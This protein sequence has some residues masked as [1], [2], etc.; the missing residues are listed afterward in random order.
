[1]IIND[2]YPTVT[3]KTSIMGMAY[4][5]ELQSIPITTPE[6]TQA[7]WLG[8][9]RWENLPLQ[10]HVSRSTFEDGILTFT[11]VTKPENVPVGFSIHNDNYIDIYKWA[12]SGVKFNGT[13]WV[14]IDYAYSSNASRYFYLPNNLDVNTVSWGRLRLIFLAMSEDRTIT[15]E[16]ITA[17][18]PYA[19]FAAGNNMTATIGDSG[20]FNGQTFT[21]TKDDISNHAIFQKTINGTTFDIVL[22][23]YT[24]PYNRDCRFNSNVDAFAA[25]HPMVEIHTTDDIPYVSGVTNPVQFQFVDDCRWGSS[26]W[27]QGFQSNWSGAVGSLTAFNNSGVYDWCGGFVG[28]FQVSDLTPGSVNLIVPDGATFYVRGVGRSDFFIIGRILTYDEILHCLSLI[29]RLQESGTNRYEQDATYWYGHVDYDTNEFL[30]DLINGSQLN[31]LVDWQLLNH[32]IADNDFT[33]DEI[34]DYRPPGP[35]PVGT[36]DKFTGDN[37]VGDITRTLPYGG[38]QFFALNGSELANFRDVLWSQPKS[39]YTALQITGLYRSSIF[40]YITSLRLFPIAA[41]L[42]MAGSNKEKIYMG[43]GAIFKDNN[44]NDLEYYPGDQLKSFR[45]GTWDLNDATFHWRNNYLDYAPYTKISIYLPYVGTCD[46]DPASIAAFGPISQAQLEL[47]IFIDTLT[48]SA[49]YYLY[50][51]SGG[52]QLLLQKTF[53]MG[54]ELPLSGNDNAQ[55]AANMLRAQFNTSKAVLGGVLSPMSAFASGNVT[56]GVAGVASLGATIGNAYLENSLAKK[57]VPVE[58][59]GVGGVYSNLAWGQVPYITVH[60]QKYSNPDNYGHTTGYLVDGTYTINSLSG[61]TICRNVDASGISKAIDKEKAEIK[62]ILESGFY[63]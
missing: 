22:A 13:K 12:Y 58:V 36:E 4:T 24:I 37:T 48:G 14:N 47:V 25:V 54:I 6:F 19:D 50:T 44:G 17:D 5:A 32:N 42:T 16:K 41:N 29:P 43:T 51:Y 40:D 28:S 26:Y 11:D 33:E 45:C 9:M 30:G 27:G 56:G 23:S 34:P 2:F 59:Q 52:N 1:M 8:W 53:K 10:Y 18:V 38:V 62:K 55:Q 31:K 57:Q 21:V 46:L 39:F 61:F 60:R 49:T 35:S 63:A 20:A 3:D 15:L 7:Y